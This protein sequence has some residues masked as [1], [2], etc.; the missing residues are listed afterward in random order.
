VFRGQNATSSWRSEKLWEMP[1]CMAIRDV[2]EQKYIRCRCQPGNEMAIVLTHPG[3]GF[4][5]GKTI[6]NGLPLEPAAEH[7][8]GVEL[9]KVAIDEDPFE[10]DR[11]EVHNGHRSQLCFIEANVNVRVR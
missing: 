3:K 10:G 6:V 2:Q 7:G 11:S 4:D 9:R 5:F 8:C 1:S